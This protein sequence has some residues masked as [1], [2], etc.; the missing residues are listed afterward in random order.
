LQQRNRS[1]WDYGNLGAERM[2]PKE[3]GRIKIWLF[4]TLAFFVLGILFAALYPEDTTA[5]VG[6][7]PNLTYILFPED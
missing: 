1:V 7:L 6:G 5:V 3:A 4:I 2:L